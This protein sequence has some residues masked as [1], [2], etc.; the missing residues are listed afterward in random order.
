MNAHRYLDEIVDPTVKEYESEPTSVRRA[1]LACIVTYHAIE[2]LGLKIRFVGLGAVAL[3][4]IPVAITALTFAI[5]GVRNWN[6]ERRDLRRA[7]LAEKTLA[8]GHRAFDAIATV[9]APFAHAGEGAS[10]RRGEG[11]TPEIARALDI[12]FTPIERLN[13]AGE[14]FEEIKA[15][16]YSL[17]AA[18]S[19]HDAEPLLVFLTVHVEIASA[20]YSKMRDILGP[21][22]RDQSA[23]IA[24]SERNDAVIWSGY[25]DPDPIAARLIPQ[26]LRRWM[27]HFDRTSRRSF[28]RSAGGGGSHDRVRA[29]GLGISSGTDWG[30]TW[31]SPA[32]AGGVRDSPSRAWSPRGVWSRCSARASGAPGIENENVTQVSVQQRAFGEPLDDVIVDFWRK[33]GCRGRLSLQA[34]RSL[35]ISAAPSNAD[36]REIIRDSLKTL[37][38]TGFRQGI[39][40]LRCRNG[41]GC[42]REI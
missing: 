1:M 3:A 4:P 2:Y 42:L 12:A 37:Q 9:R 15:L 41:L 5:R 28:A 21:R 17:A 26:R 24:R 20:A 6:R 25:A 18:F 34:K 35:V 16:R 36:F 8:L 10:R 40:Q 14:I 27:R 31:A 7:E 33:D 32:F 13:S 19:L 29:N 38:K 11:E 30:R 39:D 23:A 22:Q